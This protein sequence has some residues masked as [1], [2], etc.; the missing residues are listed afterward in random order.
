MPKEHIGWFDKSV[1]GHSISFFFSCSQCPMECCWKLILNQC[2]VLQWTFHG[3]CDILGRKI[4]IFAWTSLK[5]YSIFTE[6]GL[7]KKCS[8]QTFQ[9]HGPL[10]TRHCPKNKIPTVDFILSGNFKLMEHYYLLNIEYYRKGIKHSHGFSTLHSRG[11][12]GQ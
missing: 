9:E 11:H 6:T 4:Q 3:T 8:L 2:F 5:K 12:I 10:W 7:Y 1:N